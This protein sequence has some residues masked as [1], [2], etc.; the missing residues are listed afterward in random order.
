MHE[1]EPSLC[2]EC[3]PPPSRRH[4]LFVPSST[5][6]CLGLTI[7]KCS[8]LARPGILMCMCGG[9]A[10]Q[11][12][13]VLRSFLTPFQHHCCQANIQNILHVSASL[14]LQVV[15]YQAPAQQQLFPIFFSVPMLYCCFPSPTQFLVW[16]SASS[17]EEW[18]DKV[19]EDSAPLS[20]CQAPGALLRSHVGAPRRPKPGCQSFWMRSSWFNCSC[21]LADSPLEA[22]G[23]RQRKRASLFAVDR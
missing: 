11:L 5:S 21:A 3:E 17:N 22:Q 20:H 18:G 6:R 19:G 8:E 15:T 9:R 2:M 14:D 4:V 23:S 1:A 7:W 13:T 10:D 16:G 12:S